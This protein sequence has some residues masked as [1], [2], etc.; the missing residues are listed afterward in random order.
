M[1]SLKFKCLQGNG[2]HNHL[3]CKRTLNNSVKLAKW[4]SCFVGTYLYEAFECMSL[5]CQVCV[6]DWMFRARSSLTSRRTWIVGWKYSNW[7][8]FLWILEIFRTG[9]VLN[10]FER[11]PLMFN[12]CWPTILFAIEIHFLGTVRGLTLNN[13]LRELVELNHDFL[14][15]FKSDNFHNIYEKW[16]QNGIYNKNNFLSIAST[17]FQ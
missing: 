12:S 10:K 16:V 17:T 7:N 13:T 14:Y 6:S 3:V 8:V 4:L 11:L 2:N 1:Q 9:I 15:H 5:S